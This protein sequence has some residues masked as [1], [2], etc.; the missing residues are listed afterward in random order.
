MLNQKKNVKSCGAFTVK[1]A[2]LVIYLTIAVM[3]PSLMPVVL[4]EKTSGPF[5]VGTTLYHWIDYN[6]EEPY[7]KDL[8]GRRELMV[9]V[10]YP[11]KEKRRD[12]SRTLYP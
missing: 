5:K 11:A 3:L 4:F 2:L 7:M 1:T 9:Q 8:N 12:E 6:R 10:W